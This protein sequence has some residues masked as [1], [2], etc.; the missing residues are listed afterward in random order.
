MILVLVMQYSLFTRDHT[1]EFLLL[2]AAAGLIA[3]GIY[4]SRI[5]S[6]Q[7]QEEAILLDK[8]KA[9]EL[10]LSR[11]E[12]EVLQEM[13]TGKSN[14]EIAESLFISESTIKTHVSNLLFKLDAKRRTEA[15]EKARKMGLL[16]S[17]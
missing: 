6:R 9:K 14:K 11:R 1:N 12:T 7:K 10:N 8:Q 4:L 2:I 16:A 13:A 17:N 5:L 15:I 3:L